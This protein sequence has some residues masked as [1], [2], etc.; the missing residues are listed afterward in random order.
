MTA[1]WRTRDV[2][3]VPL[4]ELEA[5][6]RHAMLGEAIARAEGSRRGAARLLSVSRQLMQHMLRGR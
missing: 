4:H 6:V 1:R 2:G 3:R 5:E